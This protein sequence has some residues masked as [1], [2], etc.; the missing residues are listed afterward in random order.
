MPNI[1]IRDE[2]AES[3]GAR[4]KTVPEELAERAGPG[5]EEGVIDSFNDVSEFSI[6]EAMLDKSEWQGQFR[7]ISR[8]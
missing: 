5:T 8:C 4:T 3:E 1:D 2:E 7:V 6:T